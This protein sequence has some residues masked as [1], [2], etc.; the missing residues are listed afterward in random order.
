M[1]KAILLS[2]V[3]GLGTQVWALPAKITAFSPAQP[4][5]ETTNQ[6]RATFSEPMVA[7]GVNPNANIFSI[8]CS[9]Q[10]QGTAQWASDKIWV[11]DFKTKLHGNK[12]P[13]GTTCAV[14]LKPGIKT[15]KGE[16][17]VGQTAWKFQIDGPNILAIYPGDTNGRSSATVNED[18]V[19]VLGLDSEVDEASVLK[20]VYFK[21]DGVASN[22][23][24]RV[25]SEAEKRSLMKAD[26]FPEYRFS[27]DLPIVMIT[28]KQPFPANKKISLVWGAGVKGL[29]SGLARKNQLVLPYE[30]RALL[31]AEFTCERE[32]ANANCSPFSDMHL[33]FTAEIPADLA[34]QIVLR[35]ADG[36]VIRPEIE[37]GASTV[38]GV[39]FPATVNGNQSYK[40]VLPSGMKDVNGRPLSNA[41]SF[42]PDGLTVKTADFPPLAKFA[43]DFGIVEANQKPVLLPATLRNLEAQVIGKTV[44]P[45]QVSGSSVKITAENFPQVIQWM[46]RLDEKANK[47]S[48]LQDRDKSIFAGTP[49]KPVNFTIPVKDGGK[50]FEVVGIPLN[51][52]TGFYV[53][54]LQSRLLGKSLLGKDTNMYVPSGALVT[55]MVVHSKTGKEN[56]IFWVTSLDS[57]APVP[58]AMV[59]VYDCGGKAIVSAQADG[60]GVARVA[61]DLKSKLNPNA[62]PRKQTNPNEYVYSR[63]DHGFFVAAAKDGD[64]TFTHSGW[65]EGIE[66]WRFG[67]INPYE[68]YGMGNVIAHSVLDRTLLRAGDTVGMKHII[69]K[70]S[71]KGLS[72][73][74]A[75]KLPNQ[76]VISHSDT[77]T[78]YT[79]DLQWDA[80]GSAVTAFSV[81]KDAKLGLYTISLTKKGAKA[82]E[83]M[84][85]QTA[86]FQVMEFK[87]PQMKGL[88]AFPGKVDQLVQPGVLDA[89]VSVT[90][91]DG[92]PV[93]NKPVSFR[94]TVNRAY[95]VYFPEYKYM[96][97]GGEKVVEQQGRQVDNM[98]QNE[99]TVQV[100]LTLNNK[101]SAQASVPGLSGLTSVKT[102]TTQ[103]E[104]TDSNQEAQNVTRTVTVYPAGRLV[105][106]Q[107]KDGF[108]SKK[109]LKFDV[110]VVDLKGNPVEGV[111]PN[112]QLFERVTYTHKTQMVG[113]FY[114][115]ESFT[116][117]T[118]VP[119]QFNCKG[120]TDK[121]GK[122]KCAVTAPQS[123][124]YI[125]QA[126]VKDAA[127]NSSYAS[128][129]FYVQGRTRAWFPAD[130]NDRMDLIS[131]SKDLHSGQEAT[132]QVKMPFETAT[133]LVTVEREG[134]LDSYVTTV[135]TTNPVIKIPVKPEYAPNV[136]VSA[137]AVRGRINGTGADQTALVDLGKPAYKLGMAPLN[138]N[139]SNNELKVDVKA[140]KATYKPRE[141]ASVDVT[142]TNTAGQPVPNAEFALAVVDKGLLELAKN[143][144]V[145]LLQAMMGR[146]SLSVETATAQMQVIGK[147]HY[148]L[149]AKPTG[150]DGGMAPTRELFDT[151][152][153]WQPRVRTDANGKA[154]VKF[155][156]NDSLTAFQVVAVATAGADKFGK[157]EAT[158]ISQQDVVIIPSVAQTSRNGDKSAAEFTLRNATKG[159]KNVDISGTVKVAHAD[160][161]VTTINLA[162]RQVALAASDTQL[163]SLA[164]VNTPDDAVSMEYNISVKENGAQ[165]DSMRITQKVNPAVQV[166]TW[167][168]QLSRIDAKLSPIAVDMPVEALPGK[169]GVQISLLSTLTGGLSTVTDTLSKYPFMSLEY[170]VSAAVASKDEAKWAEAMKKLPAHLD[171]EGFVTYYPSSARMVGS[172]VLTAYILS[173]S[174][175]SGMAIPEVSK[176]KMIDA[177]TNYVTGRSK[178]NRSNDTAVDIFTR[179]IAAIE[180]LAR[181][182][183]AQGVWMSSLPAVA[184]EQISTT[185][186]INLISTYANLPSAPN[187]KAKLEQLQDAMQA[188]FT[189]MGTGLKLTPDR[190]SCYYCMSSIDADQLRW[191]LVVGNNSTVLKSAQ[192]DGDLSAMVQAA[193]GMMKRGAWDLTV[194][195]AYGVLAMNSYSKLCEKQNVT[196][197]TTAQMNGTSPKQL[198]WM[199]NPAGGVLDLGNPAPGQYTVR[200]DHQGTGTPWG[201]VAMNAAIPLK[202]KIERN[203]HVEKTIEPAK[204]VYKKGDVVTVTLKIK[205][206]SSLSQVSLLDPIPAGAKIE[207]SGLDTDA[208]Q[209]PS[210]T[211]YP[212][213]QELANEGYRASY[214]ILPAREV[215][216]V[217]QMRLNN[218][219]TFKV[220]A[221]RIEAIYAP[222]NFAEAPNADI[223][224]Q[225]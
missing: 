5:S 154:T 212:D 81:P 199:A 67:N 14:A 209:G 58:N 63:Y 8:E 83:E 114:S 35:G 94:Y 88:I 149:K 50:A 137:L 3:L 153:A 30:S 162:S 71:M 216:V 200:L 54:E 32:N 198:E 73:L 43:A 176:V 193:V 150:G 203:I 105:A 74:A 223:T 135:S 121:K 115:S 218:A 206:Q 143:R 187:G 103:L 139:W 222:E 22:I 169:G 189:R 23:Q 125:V 25:L 165:I 49:N 158:I 1:S 117:T 31:T 166:R 53:V 217:Y 40:L 160:G 225:P 20:N 148:G 108:S 146:R 210:G 213:H 170:L 109:N 59:T 79:A 96:N 214:S 142:I 180:V 57:G 205:A 132:F 106:L 33:S 65:H 182:G 168:A 123:G 131:E 80:N 68:S 185:A 141:M 86:T 177:L 100:P 164:D 128:D 97:F 126:E 144:T 184:P 159:A 194:A 122:L 44:A 224:V 42:Q 28:A 104:F 190:N 221:T 207:G 211:L 174:K 99:K 69:R 78:E 18:Q 220:P 16:A 45:T 167:M 21:V 134:I 11:F 161:K 52:G 208:G 163:V 62:C 38:S 219:G 98:E 201:I 119:A 196:G 13:G 93:I 116:N 91:Q 47:A 29:V 87:I 178:L 12:L 9:P 85:L 39:Q 145:D 6:I 127:G 77:G 107:A 113:G 101:G 156:M 175:Y 151:L 61:G 7:L 60:E 192:C 204:P 195:D 197:I 41:A 92:G 15:L 191:I 34:K 37:K 133:V 179:R 48:S 95:G 110:V 2:L 36:S 66:T 76:A 140:A 64:F 55:N 70:P 120:A 129:N 46:R 155:A 183:L 111:T 56:S 4:L 157:G 24:I 89:Q 17:V 75:D 10:M 186:L 90:Y 27:K 173:V 181:Y 102:V 124:N 152:L 130:N 147:R 188:R 118:L 136:F 138:V 215:T 51:Q 72:L 84:N 202:E 172:D 19:F 26:N 82:G 171:A 112:L